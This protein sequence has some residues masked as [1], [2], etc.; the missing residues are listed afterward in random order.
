MNTIAS[1]HSDIRLKTSGYILER[2]AK[3]LKQAFQRKL[4]AV[5]AGVT[6]DQWVVLD[7]LGKK[8]GMSQF[9]IAEETHKDPPTLT[10]I[11]DL[12]CEKQLTERRSDPNDRRRFNIFLTATGKKKIQQLDPIVKAFRQK[13]WDG[14]S[15]NEMKQLSR[16]LERINRNIDIRQEAKG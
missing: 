3:K 5:D 16:I 14:L 1:A 6:A 2:T 4:K 7:T 8:D 11:I 15:S 13:S 10:R 12:L 9:E